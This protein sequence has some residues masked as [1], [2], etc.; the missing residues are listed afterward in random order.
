MRLRSAPRI[1]SVR[2]TPT[3]SRLPVLSIRQPYA[4]LVVH[5]IKDIENRS[6]RTNYRGPLLIHASAN[7][8]DLTTDEIEDCQSQ[9]GIRMPEENEYQTGGVVGLVDVVDCVRRHASPWKHGPSWGWVLSNARLL[10]FRECKG[11]VGFF[12]PEWK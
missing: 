7:L 3:L 12:Y 2:W 5:G 11:A 8:V 6:W 9:S 4:W 10:K 1:E